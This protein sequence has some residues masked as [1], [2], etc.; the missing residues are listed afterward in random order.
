MWWYIFKIFSSEDAELQS[1][2]KK[3]FKRTCIFSDSKEINQNP[4]CSRTHTHTIFFSIFMN[5]PHSKSKCCRHWY[6]SPYSVLLSSGHVAGLPLLIVGLPYSSLTLAL[7]VGSYD[8]FWPISR[9]P[10]DQNSQDCLRATAFNF[11]HE[12]F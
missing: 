9:D 2:K 12:P 11:Q 10:C 7:I 4:K 8:Y 6:S 5:F 3:L 1:K